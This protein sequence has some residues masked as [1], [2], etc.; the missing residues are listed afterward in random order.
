MSHLGATS[1]RY[2][3]RSPR[4]HE[5][6][7]RFPASSR[8]TLVHIALSP[9]AAWRTPERPETPEPPEIPEIPEPESSVYNEGSGVGAM[10]SEFES[11]GAARRDRAIGE[12][13]RRVLR[14]VSTCSSLAGVPGSSQSVLATHSPQAVNAPL[15]AR[16]A[17]RPSSDP[18]L[19]VPLPDSG[20]DEKR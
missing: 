4:V 5:L 3:S 16:A 17:A 12:A 2:R 14:N 8:L 18:N 15:S 1:S 6:S 13:Q 9:A 19:A 10:P 20:R 7:I 11:S